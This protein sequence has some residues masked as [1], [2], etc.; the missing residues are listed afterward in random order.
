MKRG[1]PKVDP[2][3]VVFEF[4]PLHPAFEGHDF[5]GKEIPWQLR[6]AVLAV[7]IE[8]PAGH[9]GLGAQRNDRKQDQQNGEK[10]CAALILFR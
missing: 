9:G 2:V 5:I 3:R 6:V 10:K 1:V 8:D 7:E 4:T